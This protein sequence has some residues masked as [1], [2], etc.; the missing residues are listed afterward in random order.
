MVTGPCNAP[1]N[2]PS[3][4]PSPLSF[5]CACSDFYRD[6]LGCTELK[7]PDFGFGVKWVLFP[8]GTPGGPGMAL[9]IVEAA[10]PLPEAGTERSIRRSYHLCFRVLD[11]QAQ[12]E[13]LQEMGIPF[14]LETIPNTGVKQV[15][16]YDP[17][18]N[19]IELQNCLE[20]MPAAAEAS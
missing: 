14:T 15:L 12:M 4:Y 18:G 1:K 9:H 3:V 10:T 13:K 7:S 19:G 8:G 5:R 16:F 17:D 11:P 20:M 6:V 2:N